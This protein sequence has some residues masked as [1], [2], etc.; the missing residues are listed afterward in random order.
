VCSSDLLMAAFSGNGDLLLTTSDSGTA[1][2]WQL[3]PSFSKLVQRSAQTI[4][5]CLTGHERTEA[6]LDPEPPS[7]C[8]ETGKW[9]YDNQAWQNWLTA[10]RAGR[11]EEMPKD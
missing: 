2:V 6:F 3:Y 1:D 8:I 7:W 10:K 5:H 11:I 4:P 9:P